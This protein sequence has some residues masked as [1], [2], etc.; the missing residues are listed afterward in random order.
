MQFLS[1]LAWNDVGLAAG[2]FLIT[3]IGSLVVTAWVVVRI[4]ANYFHSSHAREFWTDQP[5]AIRWAGI[6]AKNI[7]G[8]A[9]VILGIL[10]SLPGVPG[11]GLLTILIGIILM[12]FPGKA[13]LERRVVGL[14]KILETI[15]WVRRRRGHAP[16]AL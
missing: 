12:D 6:V 9:L 4:P 5:A 15:N 1:S 11:Q 7:A 14:P 3:F 8:V 2:L 10:M 13:A 16:L